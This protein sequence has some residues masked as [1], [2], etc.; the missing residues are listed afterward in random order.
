MNSGM[1]K[2]KSQCNENPRT[3]TGSSTQSPIYACSLFQVPWE[4]M[5]QFWTVG[6]CHR[7]VFLDSPNLY[8][9]KSEYGQ[10]WKQEAFWG[11]VSSGKGR[12]ESRVKCI[13]ETELRECGKGVW[14]QWAQRRTQV[15]GL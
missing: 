10:G 3:K 15:T 8:K 1:K 13:V 2:K 12:Q 14:I 5:K 6:C 4:V 11:A 7:M 9:D